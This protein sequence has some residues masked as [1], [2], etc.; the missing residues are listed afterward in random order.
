MLQFSLESYARNTRVFFLGVG[1]VGDLPL[2]VSLVHLLQ[3][4]LAN[5]GVRK[6]YLW[7]LFDLLPVFINKI[8]LE[9]R[10]VQFIYVLSMV[11]VLLGQQ[12]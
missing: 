7:M 11:T 5:S 4:H 9:Y 10:Y 6:Q 3:V 8:L 2:N 12:K 1:V